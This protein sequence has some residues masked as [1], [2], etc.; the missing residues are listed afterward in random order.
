MTDG[1]LAL[2]PV[3][4]LWLLAGTTLASCLALPIPASLMM[5]TAG[6]FAAAG[7]FLWW[8]AVLAALAGAV[9]GD[10]IGYWA[11]RGGG[12]HIA[13]R[14]KTH[15]T[16]DTLITKAEQMMAKGGLVSVFLTRW[17]L[18]LIHI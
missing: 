15:P 1:L 12:R 13:A 18:S 16:Q 7:D 6:G 3:W 11:G 14:R 5:L 2:I 4:G 8:Q 10:Q 17:M 9:V